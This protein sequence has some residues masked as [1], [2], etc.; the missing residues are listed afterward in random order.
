MRTIA[1][2]VRVSLMEVDHENPDHP[3]Q[4]HEAADTAISTRAPSHD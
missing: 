3:S 2:P 1:G 4:G